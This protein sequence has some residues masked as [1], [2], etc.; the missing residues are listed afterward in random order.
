MK[1][2]Q[3]QPHPMAEQVCSMYAAI[4]GFMDDVAVDRIADF[5]DQFLA[6]LRTSKPEVLASIDEARD[7]TDDN[8]TAL[9]KAI[10]AFKQTFA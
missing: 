5:E 9:K 1:Q 8:D 7:I 3:Y 6:Y 10:A 2:P 4:N